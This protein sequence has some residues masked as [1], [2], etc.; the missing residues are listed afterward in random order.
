M[1]PSAT[2]TEDQIERSLA[3]VRTG[4]ASAADADLI[5]AAM[6]ADRS[7]LVGLRAEQPQPLT[8]PG[9]IEIVHDLETLDMAQT[10]H[11]L[12]I[13]AV[14]VDVS[15]GGI[16]GRFYDVIG[17]APQPERTSLDATLQWWHSE[18]VSTLARDEVMVDGTHAIPL[19]LAL[20]RYSQWLNQ[21]GEAGIWGNGSD[22][23]NAI[24]DH[25]FR[26]H[27]L[28]WQY[29]RNRCMRTLR[30]LLQTERAPVPATLTAHIAIDDATAEAAEL[31]T[32]LR[33]L[34]VIAPA[35]PPIQQ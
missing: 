1:P 7:M 32:L 4:T 15:S 17:L 6:A 21:Y 26:Q 24:L 33:Q 30:G 35:T 34:A 22:F 31:C 5:A 12:S 29:W 19:P 3:A 16:I 14:A 8:S 2:Q 23:D 27:G 20:T 13:G 28:R 10:A 9:R 18:K 11:I 25:A